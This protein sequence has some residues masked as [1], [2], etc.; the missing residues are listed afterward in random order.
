VDV[1][2]KSGHLLSADWRTR[3]PHS[4]VPYTS[5]PVLLV[6]KGNPKEIRDWADLARPGIVVVTAD[7]R[8]SGG[9]RWNF[10]S[11]YA[12]GLAQNGNDQDKALDFVAKVYKNTPDMDFSVRSSG[13]TFQLRQKGDVLITWE[14][15]ALSAAHENSNLYE[16]VAPSM[17]MR[18]EPAVAVVDVNTRKHGTE[19]A[20]TAY[21]Q[22]LYTPAGQ[23]IIA[24]HYF[25][26][27]NPEVAAKY[28][29][30]FPK[31][32]LINVNDIGG[33]ATL[34]KEFDGGGKFAA[35]YGS[36]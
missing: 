3:L 35:I 25:R 8:T 33:W 26:A 7:P 6:R 10:L 18:A 5:A 24:K 32:K 21:L 1:L 11:L 12:Y 20:A 15:E 14:N 17:T 28:A 30:Q 19:H 2:A 9:G 4:A 36:R 23:K 34:Q 22:F 16:V 29:D 27:W 31:F 13:V